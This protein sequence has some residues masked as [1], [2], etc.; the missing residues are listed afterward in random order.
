MPFLSI[1]IDAAY[2]LPV[3]VGQ[4]LNIPTLLSH[5]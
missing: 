3:T 5:F 1:L 2:H 4:K